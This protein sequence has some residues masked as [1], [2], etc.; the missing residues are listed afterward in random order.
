MLQLRR[1]VYQGRKT[2]YAQ[3][4][5]GVIPFYRCPSCGCSVQAFKETTMRYFN[6]EG[7]SSC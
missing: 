1:H 7:Y 2:F 3:N 4:K 6:M 5:N